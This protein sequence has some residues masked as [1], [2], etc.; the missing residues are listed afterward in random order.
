MLVHSLITKHATWH[1]QPIVAQ[2]GV[3]AYLG[4]VGPYAIV[5]QMG[6]KQLKAYSHPLCYW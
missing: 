5:A 6:H 4:G 2:M 1:T 3:G